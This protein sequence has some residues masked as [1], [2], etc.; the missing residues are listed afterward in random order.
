MLSSVTQLLEKFLALLPAGGKG[1][2]NGPKTWGIELTITAP[3]VQIIQW[4][5]HNDPSS[6]VLKKY[7]ASFSTTSIAAPA[8]TPVFKPQLHVV[9]SRSHHLMRSDGEWHNSRVKLRAMSV[10]DK[11]T[12]NQG[13][14]VNKSTT[15]CI[16]NPCEKIWRNFSGKTMFMEISQ[17]R[18]SKKEVQTKNRKNDDS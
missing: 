9:P 13:S 11:V 7:G 18:C 5:F 1:W 16:H 6:S 14:G 4:M 2:G 8:M 12:V 17:L 3:I 15:R 10:S